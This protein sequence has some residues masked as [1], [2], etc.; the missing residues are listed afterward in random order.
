MFMLSPASQDQ[1]ITLTFI[2]GGLTAIAFA[3]SFALPRLGSNFF[4]RVENALSNIA[5]KKG[6]AILVVGLA[7]LLLRFVVLPLQPAPLP[8]VP[9]DFS[10]LLAADTFI[11]GRLANPTPPM[12]VHFESIH[13]DMIPTYM[14]M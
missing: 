5:R 10:F 13:I 1:A 14:S 12:W 2:E 4:C 8:F 11:H 6:V 3:L 9:D 7:G